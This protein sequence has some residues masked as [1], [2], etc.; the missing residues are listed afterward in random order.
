MELPQGFPACRPLCFQPTPPDP[1]GFPT[2]QSPNPAR[3]RRTSASPASK[4]LEARVSGW[5][6][7][8]LEATGR[9]RRG[10]GR[11]PKRDPTLRAAGAGRNGGGAEPSRRAAAVRTWALSAR[12]PHVEL[13]TRAH[14]RQPRGGVGNE[15]A[16]KGGRPSL[17]PAGAWGC[18]PGAG[19]GAGLGKLS[20]S[21]R[22]LGSAQERRPPGP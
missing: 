12:G 10:A 22:G 11:R 3:H 7:R 15:Y 1:A 5:P 16:G 14:G 20:I 19:S 4:F 9:R 21:R 18:S 17:R 2:S 13:G 8:R 6:R